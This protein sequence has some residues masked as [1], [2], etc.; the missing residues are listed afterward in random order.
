M[1]QCDTCG[2][3]YM[4][5]RCQR[6]TPANDRRSRSADAISRSHERTADAIRRQLLADAIRYA[7]DTQGDVEE[8][9]SWNIQLYDELDNSTRQ[10]PGDPTSA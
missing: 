2:D 6:C 8:F 4:G 7:W 1:Q 10:E 3:I 5:E 9:V